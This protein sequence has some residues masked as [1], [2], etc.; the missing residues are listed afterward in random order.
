MDGKGQPAG[1]QPS[2]PQDCAASGLMWGTNDCPRSFS[3]SGD[4]FMTMV[5][6]EL[7]ALSDQ[8]SEML[9]LLSCQRQITRDESFHIL[10]DF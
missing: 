8:E 7:L 9:D 6:R 10:Q 3:V 5:T 2:S 4:I 1:G